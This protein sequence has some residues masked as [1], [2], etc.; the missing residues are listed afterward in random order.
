MMQPISLV[1]HTSLALSPSAPL[2]STALYC[3]LAL[4]IT[5]FFCLFVVVLVFFGASSGCKP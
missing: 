3:R 5:F 2:Y 1:H 4:E